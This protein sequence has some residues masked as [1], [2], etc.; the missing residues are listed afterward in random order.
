MAACSSRSRVLPGAVSEGQDRAWGHLCDFDARARSSFGCWLGP[1]GTCY[2]RREPD[3]WLRARRRLCRVRSL[4]QVGTKL[5]QIV[6]GKK[7]YDG[8]RVSEQGVH[9]FAYKGRRV[10]SPLDSGLPFNGLEV[11]RSKEIKDGS[12]ET[13]ISSVNHCDRLPGH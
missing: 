9:N 3:A 7:N 12:S 6:A 1:Q 4:A 11:E 13:P 8:L 2:R 10:P 5:S